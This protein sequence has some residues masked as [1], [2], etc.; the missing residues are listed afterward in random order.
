MTTSRLE[1]DLAGI[2]LRSPVMTA[3]GTFG[4]GLEY[5][6]LVNFDGLGAIVVK[7]TT[8]EPWA[9][10]PAPRIW[11]TPAGMLNAIGLENCGVEAFIQDRLPQISAY[12]LP[13]I[14]NVAG[15]SVAE[16]PKVIE[17]L[18]TAAGIAGY[19]LNISCPNV[20]EGGMAFGTDPE[21]AAS[22]T[23]AAKAVATRPVI[24]KLSPM[25]TDIRSIAMAVEAAGADAISLVNTFVGMAIDI[26]QRRPVLGNL[27]GG[28]SG[29]AIRP[30]AVHMVW[31]VSQ[32]VGIPVIGI[33]GIDSWQSALEFVLAGAQAI[34]VGTG[35]FV[36]PA[37]AREINQGLEN[38]MEDE[39]ISTINDLVGAAWQ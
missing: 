6:S 23:R 20:Q 30:L 38:Y 24:V 7:G 25:V 29:P 35:F 2:R 1:V 33:G 13:I 15:R 28:L 22:V 10:N 32:V 3:S 34:A 4:Y 11:E 12:D 17:R 5:M 9:G 31:Q 14:V 39:G 21:M 8:L 19:E 18:E 37:V 36:N 26:Y 16:Y 27:V